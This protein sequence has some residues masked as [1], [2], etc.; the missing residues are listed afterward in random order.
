MLPWTDSYVK[1]ATGYKRYLVQDLVCATCGITD[2]RWKEIVSHLANL[3]MELTKKG[4]TQVCII[5]KL[6]KWFLA[7][8]SN[9]T[10][11][12]NEAKRDDA[13]PTY[14]PKQK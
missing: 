9:K 1:V 3:L 6:L 2:D 11:A 7:D 13:E 4:K 8:P 14:Q 12:V 5:H 10:A